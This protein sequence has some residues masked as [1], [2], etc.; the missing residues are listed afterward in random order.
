[1]SPPSYYRLGTTLDRFQ[2]R[3]PLS[4]L[5]KGRIDT[6]ST[7]YKNLSTS[8]DPSDFGIQSVLESVE[9]LAEDSIDLGTSLSADLFVD[10]RVSSALRFTSAVLEIF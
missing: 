5:V 9:G 2:S 7:Y 3:R 10:G 6:L 4:H 8:V 1:M